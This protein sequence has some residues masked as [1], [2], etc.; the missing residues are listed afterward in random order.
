MK[1]KELK[2]KLLQEELKSFQG[3]DFSHLQGRWKG[4][5]QPWDYKEILLPYLKVDCEL[6]D[7]GTGGGEFLLTLNHPY[8]KTSVTEGYLPNVEL[9]KMTLE[10]LGITVKQ[11]LEEDQIPYPD[12]FFDIIL[13]RHE[14]FEAKE[15]SRVLKTGGYFITQQIGKKNM[16]ELGRSLIDGFNPDSFGWMLSEAVEELTNSGFEI[17]M[18]KESFTPI[19]FYDLGAFVYYAKIIE[20]EFP[21]FN[22]EKHFSKLL[23]LQK[24]L[25]QNGFLVGE[26]HRYLIVAKKVQ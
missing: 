1:E 9:C 19:Y 24:E 7:M 3:W 26:E 6:L 10:P 14:S 17:V 11:I 5:L 12:H 13:N 22:V 2:N 8:H 4:E 15:V 16:S 20:W 18:E 23:E 25:E 21:G